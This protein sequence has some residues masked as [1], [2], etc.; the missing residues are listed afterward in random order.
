MPQP[1]DPWG[2]LRW[3]LVDL[4]T[5]QVR[6][7]QRSLTLADFEVIVL[8]PPPIPR[9]DPLRLGPRRIVADTL[10]W[11]VRGGRGSSTKQLR[12][13]DG[14]WL[15]LR[16]IRAPKRPA[17]VLLTARSEHVRLSGGDWF[18][19]DEDGSTATQPEGS[20]RLG[21]EWAQDGEGFVELLCTTARTDVV[22]RLQPARGPIGRD[23]VREVR[24]LAGSTIRWP[25]A[26]DGVRLVPRLRSDLIRP[27]DPT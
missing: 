24:I 20:G 26:A 27:E 16:E 12:L 2:Q 8:P 14:F 9:F 17:M 6:R 7:G 10:G 11:L 23:P 5:G 18:R 21:L 25:R 22:L 13:S 3:E 4:P 1:P 15:V 19:V